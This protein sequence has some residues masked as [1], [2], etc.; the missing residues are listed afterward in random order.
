MIYN[1][2]FEALENEKLLSALEA[3]KKKVN[4]KNITYIVLSFI[5]SMLSINAEFSILTFIMFATASLFNVPLILVLISSAVGLALTTLSATTMIKI[6]AFFLVFTLITSL[7]NIEGITKKY[8]VFIKFLISTV[9]V[10]FIGEFIAGTLI[11]NIL[12]TTGNIFILSMLYFVFTA[13]IY[14]IFNI[15]KGYIYSKEESMSM[16]IVLAMALTIFKNINIV[17]FNVYNVLVTILVLIYGWKS[18]A[19]AGAAAGLVTGLVMS[20]V[21]DVNMSYIIALGFSGAIAGFLSKIGKVA[22]VIGFVLGNVYLSYYTTGFSELAMR[23]SEVLI[24]SIALLFIPKKLEAKIENLFDKNNTLKKPYENI[25]D[26]A[27]TVKNKIGAVSDVFDSLSNITLE[28]TPEDSK[29]TREIIKKYII[30]YVEN[31]CI[32]CDRKKVCLNEEKLN[33]AVDYISLKL[34]NNESI[35]K[36]MLDVIDCNFADEIIINI[37]E[38]YNSIKLSRILKQKEQENTVKLSNQ[39]K[40][41][42]HILSNIAKNIRNVPVIKNEKQQKIREELKFHGFIVYEDD[43][44]E[45]NQ[46]IEYTFVTD[47]L[48]NIDKQKKQITTLIS[49][50][51]EQNMTIKLILN[52]SKKEKSKIKLVSTPEFEI[53]VGVASEIKNGE[54]ISGDSYL[55]MELQDLKHLTVI[56]DGAGSG[57]NAS[58]GSATVINMLEKLLIG[59]FD[60]E[61]AIEIINSVLKMKANDSVFSTLDTAIINLKDAKAQFIKLGAAPTY[62][63]EDAK[64]TT[65]NNINIPVGLIKETEYVPICKNLSNNSL[66]IQIS[67]GVVNENMNP[68]DNY[69]TKYIQTMDTS[70]NVRLISDDLLKFV[71]KEN[72]NI[73]P[74]DITIIVSKVKKN[75]E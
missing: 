2:Y 59:G 38:V 16:I 19:V 41:V 69:F 36:S 6:F 57:I 58:K 8:S 34:E 39:Y 74:D 26:V 66:V 70:K 21:V 52:S 54:T 28:N 10:E 53:Q 1:K 13:G 37:N 29:E 56:S 4:F 67:D 49:D 18:G 5:V 75:K 23:V 45:E 62:I 46:N 64:V 48:N 68:N 20:L 35:D 72:K 14:V 11:V 32:S 42:S 31:S 71:L 12:D 24:A 17:T 47:I 7:I 61:K 63:L 9:I 15:S 22:I 40:E 30:D 33:L 65:L 25:L 44:I 50:I 73:L 60:E 55:S 27:S 3:F 43:F 51:L